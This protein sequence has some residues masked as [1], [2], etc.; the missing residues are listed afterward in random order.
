LALEST[1]HLNA[2]EI[3]ESDIEEHEV[4]TFLCDKSQRICT[5]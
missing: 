1:A 5:V 4:G 2:T 3:R